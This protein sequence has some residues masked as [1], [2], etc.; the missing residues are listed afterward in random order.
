MADLSLLNSIDVSRIL[1]LLSQ[2]LEIVDAEVDRTGKTPQLESLR[3]RLSLRQKFLDFVSDTSDDS[4]RRREL[5]VDCRDLIPL[6]VDTMDLGKAIPRSFSTRIQRRL[7]LQVPPRPMVVID[8]KEAAKSFRKMLED[9]IEIESLY[10]YE[11]PHQLTVFTVVEPSN[12]RII[13][14]ILRPAI[15]PRFP[16]YVLYYRLNL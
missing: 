8:A 4:S 5:L 11:S 6:I 12:V 10:D 16:T 13:L 9:L 14:I 7:S 2:A 3:S 15:L 1:K